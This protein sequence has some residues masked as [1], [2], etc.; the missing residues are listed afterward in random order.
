MSR[1]LH[2]V[3]GV[4]FVVWIVFFAAKWA[5]FAGLAGFGAYAW[6]TR[7]GAEER[8]RQA[9]QARRERPVTPEERVSDVVNRAS[10]VM[11]RLVERR[12]LRA[13]VE[14]RNPTGAAVDL[15]GVGC[16]VL[17]TPDGGQPRDISNRGSWRIRLEPD[18][19]H[20]G[21]VAFHGSDVSAVVAPVA[22]AEYRCG[23]RVRFVPPPSAP[24]GAPSNPIR[25]TPSAYR[26]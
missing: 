24:P 13:T 14:A 11:L 15:E 26:E 10:T 8:T 18:A 3:A 7:P 22:L 6:D 23:L 5:F 16:R 1:A 20:R 2:R 25:M 17:L 12:W 19:S 21:E 4:A 9:E